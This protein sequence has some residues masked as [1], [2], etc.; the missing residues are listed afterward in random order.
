MLFLKNW[1]LGVCMKSCQPSNSKGR[2][3]VLPRLFTKFPLTLED[4]CCF[5][6]FMH[7][8]RDQFMTVCSCRRESVILPKVPSSFQSKKTNN[9]LVKQTTTA[10][11]SSVLLIATRDFTVPR[12]ETVVMKLCNSSLGSSLQY[13][14][15]AAWAVWM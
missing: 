14:K 2:I 1:S 3:V 11:C 9:L 15:A 7:T 12:S 8:P 6:V 4:R 10:G 13:F 5:Y